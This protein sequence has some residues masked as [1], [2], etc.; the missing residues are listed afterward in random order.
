M[1]KAIFDDLKDTVI[2]LKEQQ[3]ESINH[4]LQFRK[5]L[6]LAKRQ[7]HLR[8]SAI[9]KSVNENLESKPEIK[10]KDKNIKKD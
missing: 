6:E 1:Y 2:T 9:T 5:C 7:P 10:I 3:R 8:W 4:G